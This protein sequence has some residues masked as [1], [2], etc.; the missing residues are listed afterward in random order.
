MTKKNCVMYLAS[1]ENQDISVT[2]QRCV[3]TEWLVFPWTFQHRSFLIDL[4][5]VDPSIYVHLSLEL[6]KN[7]L[8]WAFICNPDIWIKQTKQGLQKVFSIIIN[9]KQICIIGTYLKVCLATSDGRPR[10]ELFWRRVTFKE[11]FCTKMKN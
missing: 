1:W 4:S 9:Y 8:N 6:M 7:L 2:H 11:D 5:W 3:S 10:L